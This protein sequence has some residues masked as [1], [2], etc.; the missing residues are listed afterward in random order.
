MDFFDVN[1]QIGRPSIRQFGAVSTVAELFQ[2]LEG[3]DI[4][5]G[6]AWNIAQ[7]ECGADVGNA[8]VSEAVAGDGRV[9]GCWTILPPLTD[10]NVMNADF[11][12]RMNAENIV[13]LRAF[14]DAQ[15]FQLSRATFGSF[16]DDVSERGIPL[17]MSFLYG[18][19]WPAIYN[20]LQEY[21]KLTVVLCDLGLWGQDRQS[22]PLVEKYRNIYLESSLVSLQAGG[23]EA[24]VKTLGAEKI[25]FGSGFPCHSPHAAVLD[26]LHAE[27]SDQDKEKI[28]AGN[29]EKLIEKAAAK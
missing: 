7:R 16:L 19:E 25:L 5:R 26:V 27:I 2:E 3:T 18:M 29:L 9:F 23:L 11:L 20:L 4:T 22:W 17:L 15:R 8:M 1:L 13:A 14:P 6:V 21:P 24:A 12:D 10:A 28:A